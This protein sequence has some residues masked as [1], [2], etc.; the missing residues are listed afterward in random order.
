MI[1]EASVMK[2]SRSHPLFWVSS[3]PVR[4][5][6]WPQ[7]RCGTKGRRHLSLAGIT[8]K[9]GNLRCNPCIWDDKSVG[10]DNEPWKSRMCTEVSTTW[11]GSLSRLQQLYCRQIFVYVV[12]FNIFILQYSRVWPA[13][14]WQS[15]AHHVDKVE[16][17][18]SFG[19]QGERSVGD[20][21][22]QRNCLGERTVWLPMDLWL[23]CLLEHQ[24]NLSINV[25]FHAKTY[26]NMMLAG[27]NAGWP[28]AL[29]VLLQMRNCRD[30]KSVV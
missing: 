30:R 17:I 18:C 28:D 27:Q 26:E 2:H 11:A 15:D 22:N 25:T 6:V 3:P 8:S 23:A 12:I 10:C 21:S 24:T 9:H 13:A 14:V 1:H 7:H 19:L 5:V 20:W 4:P 29:A 16:P